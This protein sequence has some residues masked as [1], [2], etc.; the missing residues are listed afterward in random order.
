M[1]IDSRFMKKDDIL[2]KDAAQQFHDVLRDSIRTLP[3]SSDKRPTALAEK[4]SSGYAI[5]EESFALLD[6]IY[7]GYL[8]A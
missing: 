7:R 1:L 4:A 2:F 6:K 3:L 5:H 8:Q